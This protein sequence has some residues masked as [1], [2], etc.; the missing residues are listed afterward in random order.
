MKIVKFK[1]EKYGIRNGS[2]LFGYSYNDLRVPLFTCHIDS[3][4]FE[5]ACQSSL[6]KC[7]QVLSRLKDNGRVI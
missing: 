5:T 4:N 6:D 2:F 3:I 1:N 7:E